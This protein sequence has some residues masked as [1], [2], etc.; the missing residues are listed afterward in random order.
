MEVSKS[1]S[2]CTSAWH[3]QWDI[4]GT[5]AWIA[6]RGFTKVTLQFPDEL[7]PESTVVAAAIQQ[8]CIKID[9]A[10]QVS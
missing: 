6:S 5:V 10:A 4:S 8:E 1:A 3:S 2:E 9:L 7:L